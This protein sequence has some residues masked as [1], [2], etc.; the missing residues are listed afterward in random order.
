MRRIKIKVKEWKT[1]IYFYFFN[2]KQKTNIY[3]S[4]ASTKATYGHHV[5]I[6]ENTIVTAD[7]SIGKYSYVNRNSSIENSDMEIIVLYQA[8][9]G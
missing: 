1:R 5:G 8:V 7:V 6:A 3:S 2:K 4:S 9:C